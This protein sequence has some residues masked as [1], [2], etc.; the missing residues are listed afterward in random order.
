[1]K[2]PVILI[3]GRDKILFQNLKGYLLN[4]FF[5]ITE[6]DDKTNALHLFQSSKSD[7]V[8]IGSSRKNIEDALNLT[9]NI[10]LQNKKVPIILITKYS[11]EK[12]VIAGFRAGI[13]DYF[14][15]PLSFKELM[16]SINRNLAY[17]KINPPK[18][19]IENSMIGNSIVMKDIK[20]YLKKV[21]NTDS[22]V[23]ITGETGTGKEVTAKLIHRNSPRRNKPF[24]CINCAALPENLLE[25]ELFGYDRGAFTGAYSTYP[26]KLKLAD[27]GAVLLD[28]IGDM[29]P[30]AQA[31]I[32]RIIEEKNFFHIGGKKNITLDVRLIAATNQDLE[33]LVEEK[34]FRKDLF[35]R[36]NI[37]WI[38]LPPLRERKE[39]IPYLLKHFIR[40]LNCRFGREI[41]GFTDRTLEYLLNYNWPGNIREMRNLLEATF[42]N[43]PYQRIT[44][45]DLPKK[46]QM[47][48]RE[49]EALSKNERDLVIST[50]FETRWNK[51]KAAHR[52]HWSRMTLYRKMEKYQITKKSR[53]R[54]TV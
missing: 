45:A 10:R 14:K 8:I 25:S 7:L 47:K 18:V 33:R 19:H 53:P 37:A 51:S 54:K 36:L 12:R 1:M 41:E 2:N 20:D 31:K 43:H 22:N 21:S 16:E 23:L 52:L 13:N 26:G 27:G 44:F 39:D 29:S 3:V 9:K 38:H 42:I 46:F 15:M 28:E 35:Y 11:S 5:E 49:A 32:L 4:Q 50:L 40:E 24:I 30:Y 6:T 48:L 34:R 17:Y